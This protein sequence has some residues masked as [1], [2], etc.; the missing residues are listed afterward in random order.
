M[1]VFYIGYCDYGMRFGIVLFSKWFL[2]IKV[3]RWLR[4]GTLIDIGGY[5]LNK[6]RKFRR[7]PKAINKISKKTIRCLAV[8]GRIRRVL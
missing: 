7:L 4:R 1:S 3:P 5:F 2:L 6:W 8:T